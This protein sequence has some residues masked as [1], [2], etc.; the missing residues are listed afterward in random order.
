MHYESRQLARQ[1]GLKT[2]T[3][4]V[5]PAVNDEKMGEWNELAPS[6]VNVLNRIYCTAPVTLKIMAGSFASGHS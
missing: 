4:K 3:A 6:D 2:I 1:P 5:N